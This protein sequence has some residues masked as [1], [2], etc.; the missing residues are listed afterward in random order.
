MTVRKVKVK[1]IVTNI[2]TKNLS[3]AKK[4]YGDILGLEKLMDLS[5]IATYGNASKVPAQIRFCI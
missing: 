5:W 3:R 4:F 2:E 1:R